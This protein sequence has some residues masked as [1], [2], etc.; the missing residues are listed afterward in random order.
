MKF[1]NRCGVTQVFYRRKTKMIMLHDI[2]AA[3]YRMS[4]TVSQRALVIRL[5]YQK[6]AKIEKVSIKLILKVNF[7]FICDGRYTMS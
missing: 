1:K 3:T 5:H 2:L 7:S 4:V 6:D